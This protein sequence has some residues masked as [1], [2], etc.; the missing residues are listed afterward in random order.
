[1]KPVIIIGAG[2]AGY[3]LAR[4]FRKLDRNTPLT[5]VTADDGGFYS[6]PMLSNALAQKKLP[7]Q[8]VTQT[9]A[10]MA[11]Q[12]DAQ[13]LTGTRVSEIDSVGKTIDSSA[14][15]I[16]YSTLA[17]AVGAQP[18]RMNIAGDA[19]DQVLSVNNIADYAIFRS[20]IASSARVAILGAGL[21]GC[22]F[23]D[24]LAGA[25][26]TVTL[27]DPNPLPLAALA[28]PA[29]SQG[30]QRALEAR[31]VYMRL[32]TT[33]ARIDDSPSGLRIALADG[34]AFDADIVLSAVGLRPDLALA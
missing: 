20:R 16:N 32:G 12:L 18:I 30:L 23:A 14:G 2:L 33:A 19:A 29:L 3:T 1:M 8:L 25:R 9:A 11:T 34:T 7:A 15:T 6:K 10:Q 5:I 31:G 21:I 28:A 22:E 4:E 13:I 27:I 24:D 17:I 26:H